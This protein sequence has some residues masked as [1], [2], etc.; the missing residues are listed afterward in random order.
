MSASLRPT[1]AHERIDALLREAEEQNQ[2]A[3][4]LVR[5]PDSR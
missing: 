4:R 1:P 2:G 5:Q 3:A